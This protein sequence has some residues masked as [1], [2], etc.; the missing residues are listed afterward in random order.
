MV[1]LYVKYSGVG[2]GGSGESIEIENSIAKVN[3]ADEACV[4]L[5][6]QDKPTAAAV[7]PDIEECLRIKETSLE[8]NVIE[9][10]RT[11]ILECGFLNL[12]SIYGKKDKSGRA[13]SSVINVEIDTIKKTVTYLSSPEADPAPQAFVDVEQRLR[14]M[15]DRI[16]ND[17]S[18]TAIHE[19]RD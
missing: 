17:T 15:S 7:H 11:F 9:S 10:L 3:Y 4:S 16:I 13:Y 8:S 14:E 12:D 2:A 1:D 5:L 6:F 19:S 18:I